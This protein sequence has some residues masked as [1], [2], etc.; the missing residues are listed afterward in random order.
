M[1]PV[2]TAV[3]WELML[4]DRV[5]VVVEDRGAK[6]DEPDVHVLVVQDSG[7]KKETVEVVRE[8]TEDNARE[9]EGSALPA[10][11]T[12]TPA[13]ETEEEVEVEQ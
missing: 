5:V 13:I 8:D 9:L 4:D 11:D 10:G 7:G 2:A 6:T 12:T 1:V 3:G